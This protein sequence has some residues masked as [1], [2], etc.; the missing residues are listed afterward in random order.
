M[1]DA[2]R[3]LSMRSKIFCRNCLRSHGREPTKHTNAGANAG[4]VPSEQGFSQGNGSLK[5]SLMKSDRLEEERHR[6]VPSF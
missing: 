4:A 6:M 5:G 1:R 3:S 2:E